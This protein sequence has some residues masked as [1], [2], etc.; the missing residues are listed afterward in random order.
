MKQTKLV[1]ILL[2]PVIFFMFL[3]F[4]YL[5]TKVYADNFQP[6]LTN[7]SQ[8][9]FIDMFSFTRMMGKEEAVYFSI[10][11][12][13]VS[14]LI[15]LPSDPSP[16]IL[17]KYQREKSKG[18]IFVMRIWQAG[19]WMRGEI[20]RIT[21][22]NWQHFMG[23][24]FYNFAFLIPKNLNCRI[25]PI[26]GPGVDK[27][28][29]VAQAFAEYDYKVKERI[30]QGWD[31]YIA[32]NAVRD[33]TLFLRNA[34]G[35]PYYYNNSDLYWYQRLND[36]TNCWDKVGAGDYDRGDGEFHDIPEPVFYNMVSL[37]MEIHKA[38]VGLIMFPKYR[39]EVENKTKKS[40]FRKKVTVTVKYFV[41]PEYVMVFPH[42]VSESYGHFQTN[43]GNSTKSNT[44]DFIPVTGNHTFP[45][46]EFLVYQWSKTKS[47]WTGLAVFLGSI[48]IGAI[49]GGIGSLINIP[50]LGGITG[51][52]GGAAVGAIGGLVASG[53]SPTTSTTAH[54]TPFVYSKYQFD[55]STA[56]SGDAKAVADRT[57]DQWLRPDVQNTP[58]GV[59]VFVSRIDMRKA[60]L[61]GS[62]SNTDNCNPEVDQ[63]VVQVHGTDPRF[64]SIFNEMFHHASQ[65]LMK[66]KY[67]FEAPAR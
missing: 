8:P 65:Y 18:S 33:P 28:N 43:P 63:P 50:G 53:F 47:G 37:A 5:E 30:D 29:E 6:P 16:F 61:C 41:Y 36:D 52:L 44:Y 42:K 21:P 17:A 64:W 25:N 39:Q 15:P 3:T 38:G 67:P 59:G 60:V 35:N 7:L 34:I 2:S 24:H 19:P 66:Y 12:N 31:P 13:Q 58:G 20:L 32:R 40:A 49:T 23:T 27:V 62:P 56:W 14:S 9:D 46:D 45:V 57:F 51:V 48:L 54:F 10:P 1:S 4:P 55:P 11:A 26:E 22:R